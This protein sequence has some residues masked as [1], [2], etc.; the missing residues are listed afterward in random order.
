MIKLYSSYIILLYLWQ[1]KGRK[2]IYRMQ[3]TLRYRMLRRQVSTQRS[4]WF[5]APGWIAITLIPGGYAKFKARLITKFI[6]SSQTTHA[7]N[8]LVGLL[9]TL[10]FRPSKTDVRALGPC[11]RPAQLSYSSRW[12]YSPG[13]LTLFHSS[14]TQ[15][16]VASVINRPAQM[17]TSSTMQLQL[18]IMTKNLDSSRVAFSAIPCES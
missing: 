2:N 5:S 6:Y 17:F 9:A 7:R 18:R 16:S 14:I 4:P 12:A 11:V 13:G 10:P 3:V 15:S 8:S 1:I